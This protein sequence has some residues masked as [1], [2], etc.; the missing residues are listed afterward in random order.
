MTLVWTQA[1]TFGFLL[2]VY[3]ECNS[4][5][6]IVFQSP[7]TANGDIAKDIVAHGDFVKDVAFEVEDLDGL[8]KTAKNGGAEVIKGITEDKDDDG[9]VRYAVL[10]TVWLFDK[11]ENIF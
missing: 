1:F 5:I 10:K 2:F 9:A 3:Q 7:I 6:T 4:Q 8:M 11:L